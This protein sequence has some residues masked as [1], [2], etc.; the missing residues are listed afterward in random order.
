MADEPAGTRDQVGSQ[1]DG[2]TPAL[3]WI[4]AG[5]G[6]IVTLALFGVIGKEALEGPDRRPPDLVTPVERTTPVTESW[7]VEVVVANR[8]PAT[9][10]QVVVEGNLLQNGEVT[11]TGK[12]TFDYVPGHSE[13]HGGLILSED[14]SA[15]ELRLRALGYAKP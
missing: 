1:E 7:V 12:A 11:A 2:G 13:V 4:A 15:G 3:E 5:V 10:A 6:L 9:A 8:S 14:P